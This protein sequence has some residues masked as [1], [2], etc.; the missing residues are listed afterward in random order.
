MKEIIIS[1]LVGICGTCVGIVINKFVEN[2]GKVKFI[3]DTIEIKFYSAISDGM[4]G[5]TEIVEKENATTFE[6]NLDLQI[7][8]DK[9]IPKVFSKIIFIFK[10]DNG[11]VVKGI[12]NLRDKHNYVGEQKQ[13]EEMHNIKIE[14]K[15]L[16]YLKLRCYLNNNNIESIKNSKMYFQY[17]DIVSGKVKEVFLIDLKSWNA[18][19]L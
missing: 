18:R 3:K 7:Y 13:Y 9:D 6:C 1:G 2:I 16:E 5:S 12:V 11:K 4:G 15:S 14:S 19:E 10:A 17:T 8:N